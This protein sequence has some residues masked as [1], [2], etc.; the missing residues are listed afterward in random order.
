[1]SANASGR[2]TTTISSNIEL[3]EWGK[4]LGNATVTA[5]ILYRLVI[6]AVRPDI[7]GSSDSQHLAHLRAECTTT[8]PS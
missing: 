6:T 1:M 7:D 3:S 8:A 2:R 5:A 4:Y